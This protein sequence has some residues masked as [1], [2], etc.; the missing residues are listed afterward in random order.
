V[1]MTFAIISPDGLDGTYLALVEEL[2]QVDED[3][4]RIQFTMLQ[5]EQRPAAIFRLDTT[6]D[7]VSSMLH[8]PADS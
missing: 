6:R 3:P 2:R 5:D 8:R 1:A 4:E 7:V